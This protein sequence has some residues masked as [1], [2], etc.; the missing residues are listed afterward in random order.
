MS[1]QLP[2]FTGSKYAQYEQLL[3]HIEAMIC[4]ETDLIANLE[5]GRAHV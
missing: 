1:E 4:G 2:L 3:P 5:I